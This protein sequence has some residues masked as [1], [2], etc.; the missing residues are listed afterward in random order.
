MKN[1]TTTGSVINTEETF[2]SILNRIASERARIATIERYNL[3]EALIKLEEAPE[4]APAALWFYKRE[5]RGNTKIDAEDQ[6]AWA[7]YFLLEENLGDTRE[8]LTKAFEE[9][10]EIY[11]EAASQFWILSNESS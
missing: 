4:T 5:N 11:C 7:D 2:Q 8:R 6:E 1:P 10:E 9:N 3:I